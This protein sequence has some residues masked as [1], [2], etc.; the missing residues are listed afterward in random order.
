LKTRNN[1]KRSRQASPGLA[2][3]DETAKALGV[4]PK[5]VRKWISQRRLPAVHL[6]RAVR[7]RWADIERII[8]HGLE[9]F[10]PGK[11]SANR[12]VQR[13]RQ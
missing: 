6:G 5:T 8:D 1:H 11:S 7:L 2:N 12:R 3:V 10:E 13:D 4:A 9:A